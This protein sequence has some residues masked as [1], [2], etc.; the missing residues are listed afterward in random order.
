MVVERVL[1]GANRFRSARQRSMG[2]VIAQQPRYTLTREGSQG[3]LRSKI[4]FYI[5]D[6]EPTAAKLCEGDDILGFQSSAAV[7]SQ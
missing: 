7:W 2:L 4:P 1:I 5:I 3:V 6:P